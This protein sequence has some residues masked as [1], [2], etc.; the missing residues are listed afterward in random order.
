M[1]KFYLLK[2]G[3]PQ[4]ILNTSSQKF[5]K[6]TRAPRQANTRPGKRQQVFQCLD[7]ASNRLLL[8][9]LRFH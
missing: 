4:S 7:R 1:K 5:S 2:L 3:K 6:S 9:M 8:E